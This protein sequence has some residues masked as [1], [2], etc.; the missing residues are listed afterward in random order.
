MPTWNQILE[1]IRTHNPYDV[2]RNDLLKKI[3]K[4]TGRNVMVY[5]SGWLQKPK[6]GA[7]YSIS[8]ED[9]RN[10]VVEVQKKALKKVRTDKEMFVPMTVEEVKV[11]F[12]SN[13]DKLP[14]N[15][16][17]FMKVAEK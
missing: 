16:F 9:K 11:G 7:N 14:Y 3:A 2:L 10:N 13:L 6:G 1:A 4:H 8:D 5:Y 17:R 12:G 15:T